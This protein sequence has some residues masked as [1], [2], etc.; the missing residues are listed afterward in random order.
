VGESRIRV[1][2]V[3]NWR[4]AGAA[5][6]DPIRELGDDASEDEGF[7]LRSR[8]WHNVEEAADRV[9]TDGPVE[10][11]AGP[12]LGMAGDP[13]K[14]LESNRPGDSAVTVRPRVVPVIHV[15]RHGSTSEADDRN[16]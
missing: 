11:T 15:V 6:S 12:H 10:H 1:V 5:S 4:L 9:G 3:P 2:R 13:V 7:Q 16:D 14:P 8:V